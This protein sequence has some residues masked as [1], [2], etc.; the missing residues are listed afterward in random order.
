MATTN[1][2]FDGWIPGVLSNSQLDEICR[3]GFL[4]RSVPQNA[5]GSAVDLT[6]SN[7]GYKMIQGSIKPFGKSFE[8]HIVS[9]TSLAEKLKPESDGTYI[10]NARQ[11][12]LF[13]LEQKL[14]PDC[15]A[16]QNGKLYGQATAKSSV[17][18]MDVLARL[19]VDGMDTYEGFTPNGL[20]NGDGVMYLEVTPITFDIRVKQGIALSQLRFF[21]GHPDTA[22]ISGADLYESVLKN[23][24]ADGSLSVDLSETVV[25]SGSGCAF[26]AKFQEGREPVRMWTEDPKPDPAPFW[27]LISATPL[28]K[29][30]RRLLKI[31]RE[32]FYILRSKEHIALPAGVA[33]YCRA[34]DET[35]G[36][37]RIHYAGFVHPCFGMNRKDGISGTPLIFEVRGHDTEVALTDGEKMARLIFYRMSADATADS[38]YQLQTLQLS[39]FFAPWN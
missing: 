36:E 31:E 29:A 10:L 14:G 12:Y 34:T 16:S 23:G 26:K 28:Q 13:R 32:S 2:I 37:M 1:S 21:F 5:K 27:D 17:G 30:G 25:G 4:E 35:I 8:H 33:V 3:V 9:D 20:N 38:T 22:E 15:R 7:D 11:T 19:I 6:L 39:N 24:G 18:R